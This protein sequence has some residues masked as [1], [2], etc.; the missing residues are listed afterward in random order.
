MQI[1]ENKKKYKERM[2]DGWML[3]KEERMNRWKYIGYMDYYKNGHNWTFHFP[4][5]PSS[6]NQ[7][8]LF[9]SF[10]DA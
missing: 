10:F 4:L 6:F 1:K 8:F 5:S 2:M 9:S 3:P 7:P